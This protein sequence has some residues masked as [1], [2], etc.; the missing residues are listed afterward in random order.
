MHDFDLASFYRE[1][2]APVRERH[3]LRQDL[4]RGLKD[5]YQD[6]YG[7]DRYGAETVLILPER[8]GQP[9]IFGYGA[10][11]IL[12]DRRISDRTKRATALCVLD[13]ADGSTDMGVPYG[14]LLTV[15]HLARLEHLDTTDFRFALLVTA[16]SG[17]PY[18][19][20]DRV[21]TRAFFADLISFAGLPPVERLFWLHSLLTRLP[22]SVLAGEVIGSFMS[23]DEF[24]SGERR[25][26]C[27]SWVYRRQ[28]RLPV[29][30]PEG[31]TGRALY[32][33]EHMPFWLAHSPSWPTPVMIR[34]GLIWLARLGEKP[35][36]LVEMALA[37]TQQS[38]DVVHAAAAEILTEHRDTIDPAEVRRLVDVGIA[39][40]GHLVTRR[41][42]Y[43]L[44]SEL[45]GDSYL[46]RAT[47]DSAG[48]V[49]QW[50]ARQMTR[51][52]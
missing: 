23:R 51:D 18:E 46:Q 22:D 1:V 26:L 15:H 10:R 38:A 16:G 4:V 44:G 28:P 37:E 25:E 24:A 49:R 14:L 40:R 20:M 50:A 8:M 52:H 6:L 29:A 30:E 35:L 5:Y 17:Q 12:A 3:A 43:R 47:Q 31:E 48:S 9:R 34:E 7:Y 33:A 19:G 39:M 45:Y 11:R 27:W 21:Q 36:P 2:G 41:R 42:F 13:Q 32:N